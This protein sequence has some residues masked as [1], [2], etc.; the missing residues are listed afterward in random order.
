[1]TDGNRTFVDADFD[2]V[3]RLVNQCEI[4]GEFDDSPRTAA[5]LRARIFGPTVSPGRDLHVWLHAGRVVGFVRTRV[6][7]VDG[8]TLAHLDY[9]IESVRDR[10]LEIEILKWSA[11][12]TASECA[13]PVTLMN[14]V[15]RCDT[16]R[17]AR[18]EKLGFELRRERFHMGYRGN[19]GTARPDL[20]AGFK[21]RPCDPDTEAEAY[22]EMFNSAF[23]DTHD[24]SPMTSA[25]FLHDVE[26][27]EYRRDFDRVLV[28]EAGELAGFCYL[29]I[30]SEVPERGQIAGLGVD[31]R[32][33][34]Q[35]LGAALL[36]DG[37]ATLAAAG[38]TRIDLNVDTDSKTGAYRLYERHDFVTE[39]VER[40]LALSGDGFGRLLES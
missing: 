11:R 34:S 1:M 25:E 31:S 36:K 13:G 32:W 4:G 19:P 30:D 26:G 28:N 7:V 27:S 22:V 37:L 21:I 12:A 35:G 20:P 10:A 8:E 16:D 18:L 14:A 5:A 38:T 39:Y 6:E 29:E 15:K 33:R 9:S 2:E 3:L 24:F 40:R 23:A 17:S